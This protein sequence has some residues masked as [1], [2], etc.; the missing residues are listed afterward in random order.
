LHG[1]RYCRGI[2]R[3]DGRCAIPSIPLGISAVTLTVQVGID[4]ITAGIKML[5]YHLVIAFKGGEG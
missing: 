5:F 3:G 1:K 2:N 4:T